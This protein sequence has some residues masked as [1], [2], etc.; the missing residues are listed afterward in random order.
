[1]TKIGLNNIFWDILFSGDYSS[2]SSNSDSSSSS[3][4]DNISSDS[5]NCDNLTPGL[6]KIGPVKP[7]GFGQNIFGRTT[8]NFNSQ[9][10]GQNSQQTGQTV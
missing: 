6:Q 10:I 4:S 8:E 1:M 7:C 9:Q 2:Y 5:S 3:I